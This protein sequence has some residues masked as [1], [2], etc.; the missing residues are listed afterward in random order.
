MLTI[1]MSISI[2]IQIKHLITDIYQLKHTA[3][4][5]K[6]ERLM[7]I[8]FDFNDNTETLYKNDGCI[9]KIAPFGTTLFNFINFN[10]EKYVEILQ[11]Y[12]ISYTKEKTSLYKKYNCYYMLESLYKKYEDGLYGHFSSELLEEFKSVCISSNECERVEKEIELL[13]K[14]LYELFFCICEYDNEEFGKITRTE[15]TQVRCKLF[16]HDELL[17]KIFIVHYK[18]NLFVHKYIS[19]K[20]YQNIEFFNYLNTIGYMEGA[21]KFHDKDGYED[22]YS[23]EYE[24][25]CSAD[26]ELEQWSGKGFAGNYEYYENSTNVFYD[27]DIDNIKNKYINTFKNA[28]EKVF[29]HIIRDIL[30]FCDITL[31]YIVKNNFQIKVCENCGK[32]FIPFHRSDTIYCD[33]MSPQDNKKNCKEYGSQQAWKKTLA[34]NEALGMYRKLYMQKQM[35]AKRNPDIKKYINDFE[36]FKIQ[37][38]QWKKYVKDGTKTEKEFLKWLESVKG[39]RDE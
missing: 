29:R 22:F 20:F 24:D 4:D 2:V 19:D 35:L 16:E 28:N 17:R 3:L 33:R 18:S 30:E 23:T 6:W 1:K 5:N 14:D 27:Y 11:K 31:Y 25:F 8:I 36:D 32:Y 21:A 7:K 12:N 34:N 39:K 15:A 26:E 38:K 37:S 9:F 13:D 10:I